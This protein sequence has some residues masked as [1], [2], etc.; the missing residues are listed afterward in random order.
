MRR[1][2]IK[3]VLWWNGYCPKHGI[4]KTYGFCD[5][6]CTLCMHEVKK[7]RETYID[8]LLEEFNQ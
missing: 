8:K 7:T 1:L 4:P 2:Y 6:K 5:A 3:L